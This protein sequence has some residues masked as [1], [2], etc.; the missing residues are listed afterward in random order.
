[1][2][3]AFVLRSA[4]VQ[5]LFRRFVIDFGPSSELI[6]NS[7]PQNPIIPSIPLNILFFLFVRIHSPL[8]SAVCVP[9][10]TSNSAVPFV[11]A[12]PLKLLKKNSTTK[13]NNQTYQLFRLCQLCRLFRLCRL[14]QL[15]R[16]FQLFRLCRFLQL[17]RLFS[18]KA[19]FY[20]VDIFLLFLR[21]TGYA[22]SRHLSPEDRHHQNGDQAGRQRLPGFPRPA[23][24]SPE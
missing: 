5:P 16:L 4:E 19:K 6:F 24:P 3:V 23:S 22:P 18:G 11:G 9:C 15:C 17:F 10:R 13:N 21:H 1:M 14:L 2:R 12:I 8:E 7:P 20:F